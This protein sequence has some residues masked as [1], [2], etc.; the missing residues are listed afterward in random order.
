MNFEELSDWLF[1]LISSTVTTTH[2]RKIKE[3][4]HS[5]TTSTTSSMKRLCGNSPKK[6][7]HQGEV[8]DQHEQTNW[9]TNIL[10]KTF[11]RSLR[12][13][14]NLGVSSTHLGSIRFKEDKKGES[15]LLA[16]LPSYMERSY[17][18]SGFF[19]FYGLKNIIHL[20]Y[21]TGILFAKSQGPQSYFR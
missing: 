8:Q 6:S 17:C 19:C 2:W 18:T 20:C 11:H 5:L 21:K 4:W 15:T 12:E 16:I 13:N 1:F 9:Q 3:C 7:S 14:S 10:R